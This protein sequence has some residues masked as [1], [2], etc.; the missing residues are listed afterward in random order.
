MATRIAV[1]PK[2]EPR[3]TFPSTTSPSRCSHAHIPTGQAIG[4]W[5]FQS[6]K[7]QLCKIDRGLQ[8]LEK[9]SKKITRK[10][11]SCRPCAINAPAVADYTERYS[12]Q[13]LSDQT[14]LEP[15]SD[16]PIRIIGTNACK[17]ATSRDACAGSD[18]GAA[19]S[20]MRV[21]A[22]ACDQGRVAAGGS[23]MKERMR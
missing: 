22:F 8:W 12:S 20:T 17:A 6:R 1:S 3:T 9:T 23:T 18:E 11:D 15:H 10:F 13:H 7:R 19:A 21:T 16:S 5:K 2:E 14:S 4:L